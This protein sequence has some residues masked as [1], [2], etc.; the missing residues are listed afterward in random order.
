M[1]ILL[2]V[3]L[4]MCGLLNLQD[5]SLL[6]EVEPMRLFGN[7]H[8]IVH[9]HSTLWVQVMFPALEK[10]RNTRSLIDPTDLQ[11]GFSTVSYMIYIDIYV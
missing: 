9:L 5:N 11:Q 2:S 1:L 10:A 7:I 3:Q 6:G 4:F 8:D